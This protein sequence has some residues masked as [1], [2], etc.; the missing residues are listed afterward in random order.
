M[1]SNILYMTIYRPLFEKKLT[2]YNVLGETG[3]ETQVWWILEQCKE[4]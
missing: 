1:N 4:Q 2:V 3:F